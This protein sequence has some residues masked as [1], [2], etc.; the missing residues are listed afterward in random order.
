M[1]RGTCR[2]CLRVEILKRGICLKCRSHTQSL[3][4]LMLKIHEL[5]AKLDQQKYLNRL[6]EFQLRRAKIKI[7]RS[8]N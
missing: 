1:T 5:Q 6:L 4:E 8:K 7:N 2:H 3:E